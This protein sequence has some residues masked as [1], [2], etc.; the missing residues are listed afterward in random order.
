M[1]V[2]RLIVSVHIF[3]KANGGAQRSGACGFYIKWPLHNADAEE[4]L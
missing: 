1:L 3:H 4:V 2:H